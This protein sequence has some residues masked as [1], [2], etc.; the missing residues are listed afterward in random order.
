MPDSLRDC[1]REV[2][3]HKM[4]GNPHLWTLSIC[5]VFFII[6]ATP[7]EMPPNAESHKHA[8]I[9]VPSQLKLPWAYHTEMVS[10]WVAWGYSTVP[11]C[12]IPRNVFC[13]KKTQY[14]YLP[15]A[16]FLPGGDAEDEPEVICTRDGPGLNTASV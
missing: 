6:G 13:L 9:L 16:T 15:T 10:F 3:Q 12:S 1:T 14:G 8:R 5:I 11:Y 4:L 2:N 7:E